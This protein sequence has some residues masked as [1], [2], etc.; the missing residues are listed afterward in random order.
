MIN[1]KI[2]INVNIIIVGCIL[3]IDIPCKYSSPQFKPN[4]FTNPFTKK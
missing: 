2:D 1:N 3:L 4:I